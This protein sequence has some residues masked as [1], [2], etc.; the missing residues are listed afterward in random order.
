MVFI[1][2]ELRKTFYPSIGHIAFT[3]LCF[4]AFVGF[5]L[6]EANDS[7]QLLTGVV[8]AYF[9]ASMIIY[10]YRQVRKKHLGR[11]IA[12]DAGGV[13]FTGDY[14]TEKLSPRKGFNEL[15]KKLKESHV[16]VMLTNQNIEVS[17]F[18]TNKFGL[19]LIFDE[20]IS[21]GDLKA[22]KPDPTIYKELMKKFNVKP[23]KTIFVDDDKA[24]VDA[25]SGLGIKAIQ[26]KSLDQLKE[27]LKK[28]GV[29]A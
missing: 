20:V 22:K 5:N 2:L 15:L 10:V 14:F 23:L 1:D 17:Q 9:T 13:Y 18:L 19:D 8:F 26:F 27:D 21:S 16:V 11:V 25:A 24:N 28:L 29:K 12:F 7:F 3:I 6:I 4:I